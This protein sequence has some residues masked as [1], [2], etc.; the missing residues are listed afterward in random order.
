VRAWDTYNNPSQSSVDF[1]VISRAKLELGAVR[2]FPNP[3]AGPTTWQ[4]EHNSAGDSLAADWSITDGAGRVVWAAE[5]S[6]LATSSVLQA[7][8][9]T[10]TNTQGTPLNDG[11]FIARVV[12][13]RVKDNQVVRRAERLILLRP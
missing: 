13:R 10:G 9:W 5:W 2:L 4:V 3:S 1:E 12:V 11:W 7:P 8:E 6:G